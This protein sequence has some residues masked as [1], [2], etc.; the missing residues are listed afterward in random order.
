MGQKIGKAIFVPEVHP[1]LNC[2]YLDS[3]VGVVQVLTAAVP[4][5]PR[6]AI[7][8]LWESFNDV[9]EG[10]GIDVDEMVE[11]FSILQEPLDLPRKQ[12][13][14][15]VIDFFRLL[16]TDNVSA[17]SLPPPALRA[18]IPETLAE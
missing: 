8:D 17:T 10:Y 13:A 7:D 5:V 18:A 3:L 1:F 9:A 16:D 11:I 6:D 4:A 15:K 2:K 12:L 14:N